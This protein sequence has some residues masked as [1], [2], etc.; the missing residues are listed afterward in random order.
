MV[1]ETREHYR[2]AI[3]DNVGFKTPATFA[4][5]ANTPLNLVHNARYFA[6]FRAAPGALPIRIDEQNPALTTAL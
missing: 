3:P 5:S 1:V 4:G 6:D 2:W